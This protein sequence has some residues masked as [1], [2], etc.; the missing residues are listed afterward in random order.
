MK[1]NKT[2]HVIC[3]IAILFSTVNGFSQD[4]NECEK[5]IS[6][7]E[8]GDIGD[9]INEQYDEFYSNGIFYNEKQLK[10]KCSN[11]DALQI[12]GGVMIGVGVGFGIAGGVLMY[13]GQSMSYGLAKILGGLMLF[14]VGGAFTLSGIILVMSGTIQKHRGIDNSYRGKPYPQNRTFRAGIVENGIGFS[15]NF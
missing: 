5:T 4:V 9:N 3:I 8:A 12:A 10:A 6:A 7:E 11:G 15:L 13:R 14:C 2:K 1:K